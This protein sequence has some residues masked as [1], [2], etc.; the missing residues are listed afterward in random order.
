TWPATLALA[1]SEPAA[2][3]AKRRAG[4]SM[5]REVTDGGRTP[6]GRLSAVSGRRWNSETLV[7]GV[8][9]HYAPAIGVRTLLPEHSGIGVGV[10]DGRRLARCLRCDAWIAVPAGTV[11]T[12]ARESLPE[13]ESLE[14]PRRGKLLR[15]AIIVRLI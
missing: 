2:V 15:E 11:G 9:G 1:A 14:V 5:C 10:P 13:L 6:V 4:S 8:R 12:A 7:C 3:S